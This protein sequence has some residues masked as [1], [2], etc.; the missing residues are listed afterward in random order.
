MSKLLELADKLVGISLEKSVIPLSRETIY[1]PSQPPT[2]VSQ[3]AELSSNNSIPPTSD[4]RLRPAAAAPEFNAATPSSLT[5][6]PQGQINNENFSDAYRLGN[7]YGDG[8]PNPFGLGGRFAGF[9]SPVPSPLR[10]ADVFAIANWFRNLSREFGILIPRPINDPITGEQRVERTAESIS[11]GI[12]WLASQA[13]LASLNPNI[14][15]HGSVAN[16]IWNPLSLPLSLIPGSRPDNGVG[17]T[18]Q[19]ALAGAL[20]GLAAPLINREKQSM[21]VV[22]A[23]SL[24]KKQV[25][26]EIGL[27]ESPLLNGITP[28]INAASDRDF[29][30]K[31]IVYSA[32]P[33]LVNARFYGQ[34]QSEVDGV[35]PQALADDETY[36]QFMFQDLRDNPAKFMYFRAFIKEG[37]SENFTPN[38]QVRNYYGR[39]DGVPTYMNTA[40]T[41]NLAFDMAAFTPADLPTIWEKIHK[42]QSM[43]YPAFDKQGFLRA[44]PI[45][46]MRV[47]DVISTGKDGTSTGLPGYLTSLNLSYN[48]STWSVEP[49]WQVPHKITVTINFTALHE[50]NIGVAPTKDSSELKFGTI[51]T[52]E[53]GI[54][55]VS[56]EGVRGVMQAVKA[57][58]QGFL[59]LG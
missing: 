46:R 35:M 41:V 33:L 22:K 14:P 27:P 47:G 43:V 20:A 45:I 5:I 59:G 15:E 30:G 51:K 53:Q 4:V 2:S 32:T 11:K 10:H 37:L 25:G 6:P 31:G 57:Y 1:H 8:F 58:R 23:F 7:V 38:W 9:T 50:E 42:L 56:P 13:Y 16:Q 40:R 28:F 52:G 18:A 24:A 55:T 26:E 17:V 54:E 29:D 36:F 49:T 39:V 12:T 19:A 34:S 48:D 44:A 3:Q 21:D